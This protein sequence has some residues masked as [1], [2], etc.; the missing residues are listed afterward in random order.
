MVKAVK[1]SW[2]GGYG[3]LMTGEF[4]KVANT[5]QECFKMSWSKEK[6]TRDR[7]ASKGDNLVLSLA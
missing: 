2:W 4:K 5:C 7:D 3:I 1:S 6:M